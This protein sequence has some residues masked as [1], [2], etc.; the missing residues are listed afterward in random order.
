MKIIAVILALAAADDWSKWRGPDGN[1]VSKESD[2]KVE[3][4]KGR[5]KLK[6]AV[7][8]GAGHCSVVIAGDRLYTMGNMGGNDLVTCLDVT[9]GKPKW[10]Y[11]YKCAPGGFPGPRAT[12]VLD[13]GHLYTLSQKGQAFCL[14][15]TKGRVKWQ[16]DLFREFSAKNLDYG[17]AGSPLVI[18]NA[19]IYNACN[20]GIALDKKT[21]K[22]LWVSEKSPGGYASPVKLTLG[23]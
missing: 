19:V 17:L 13:D 18:G 14:E 5:P 4:L 7:N 2:W 10:R 6:W 15:I 22:P 9:K 12:A 8:V 20:N 3:A 16:K 1:G 23:D 21:G 11:A